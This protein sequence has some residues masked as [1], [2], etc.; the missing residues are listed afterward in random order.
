MGQYY[1][2]VRLTDTGAAVR[3]GQVN[4]M[5]SRQDDVNAGHDCPVANIARALGS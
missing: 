5:V 2:T 4:D 3:L 1:T